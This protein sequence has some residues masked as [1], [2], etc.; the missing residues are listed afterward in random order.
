[1]LFSALPAKTGAAHYGGR[2][3]FLPDN[4]L[5][6]TLGDGFD[7][8]EQA[9][10]TANHLGKIVRLNRDGSIPRTI[11]WWGRPVPQ[12]KFTAGPSQCAGHRL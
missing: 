2:M 8:R 3:A 7:W 10:N 4:T 11:R 5:V 9:Q 12:R 1:M 6:L